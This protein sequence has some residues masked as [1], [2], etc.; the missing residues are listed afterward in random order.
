VAMCVEVSRMKKSVC[1]V[2][3]LNVP[4]I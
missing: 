1:R 3:H 2:L 4:K